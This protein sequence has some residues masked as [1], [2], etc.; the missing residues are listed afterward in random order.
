[1]FLRRTRRRVIEPGPDP[2][3]PT[4]ESFGTK[5]DRELAARETARIQQQQRERELEAARVERKRERQAYLA[6]QAV[7]EAQRDR[8]TKLV[9]EAKAERDRLHQGTDPYVVWGEEAQRTCQEFIDYVGA[10]DFKG[11]E[12]LENSDPDDRWS[13]HGYGVACFGQKG[14]YENYGGYNKV[15]INL[16]RNLPE[17]V[18]AIGRIGWSP[19]GKNGVSSTHLTHDVFL[20]EDGKLRLYT[21]DFEPMPLEDYDLPYSLPNEQFPNTCDLP[22]DRPLGTLTDLPVNSLSNGNYI[23]LKP[24]TGK[25]ISNRLPTEPAHTIA[26]TVFSEQ[27]GPPSYAAD[28]GEEMTIP[29][30]PSRISY[31]LIRQSLDSILMDYVLQAT[32]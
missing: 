6:E 29:E 28:T 16:S 18:D 9:S 31:S 20:C 30:V 3:P 1:M 32:Q 10:R 17:G 24:E 27:A 25:R 5:I 2:E 13:I 26:V 4:Y 12:L 8:V 19:D 15:A 22:I 7:R 14:L 21:T 11:S 23:V